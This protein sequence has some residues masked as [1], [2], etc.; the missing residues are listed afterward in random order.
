MLIQQKGECTHP[1]SYSHTHTT[2]SFLKQYNNN[3]EVYSTYTT[4]KEVYSSYT[5]K[6][7]VYSTYI[8][9]KEVYST[10]TT[11]VYM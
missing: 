6:K 10:Y 3:K 1:L 2:L 11:T 4:N 5:T 7:E 9:N 8:T